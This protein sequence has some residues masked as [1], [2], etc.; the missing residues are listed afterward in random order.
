MDVTVFDEYGIKIIYEESLNDVLEIEEE[1]VKIGSFYIA[2]HEFILDSEIKEPSS[3]I[4]R[5][6]MASNLI[7]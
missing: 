1:L 4:D 7:C 2:K 3:A 6:E 5:A